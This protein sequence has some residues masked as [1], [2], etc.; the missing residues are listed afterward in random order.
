MK[1]VKK[2]EYGY[3]SYEKKVT[4]IRTIL[5][6]ALSIA[7]YVIGYVTTK[8]NKNLLTVVAILGMLPASKS[9]VNMIMY[10]K[11]K[12]CSEAVWEKVL[13]KVPDKAL[14]GL[15]VLYDL[16]FTSYQKNFQ[17]SAAVIK[18]NCICALTEDAKCD[19]KAGEK[20]IE[21]MLTKNGIK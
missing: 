7:L 10:L 5:Y 1:R 14:Y 2:G 21:A 9:A 20:H 11:A 6:F 18:G 8:T 17:V 19:S 3:L 12:G 15:N 16:Y 4:V 13:K